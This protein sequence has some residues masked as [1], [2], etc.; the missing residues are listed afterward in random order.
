MSPGENPL[1][2]INFRMLIE[3]ASP[4]GGTGPRTRIQFLALLGG[5]SFKGGAAAIQ[6]AIQRARLETLDARLRGRPLGSG[7]IGSGLKL[8]LGEASDTVGGCCLRGAGLGL[9]PG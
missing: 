7:V 1:F 2:R 8:G 5:L 4:L 6:T 3:M 9:N